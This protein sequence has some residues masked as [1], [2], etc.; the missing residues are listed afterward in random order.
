MSTDLRHRADQPHRA[1]PWLVGLGVLLVAGAV[2]ALILVGGSEHTPQDTIPGRSGSG[3]PSTSTAPRTSVT[4]T[5]SDLRTV[6]SLSGLPN[7]LTI[8]R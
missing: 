8:S 3:T 4:S 5:A 1:W 7:P 2:T 6:T